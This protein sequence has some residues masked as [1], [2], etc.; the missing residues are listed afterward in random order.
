MTK[1]MANSIKTVEIR[2]ET[3]KKKL[4]KLQLLKE[5]KKLILSSR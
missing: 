3:I 5:Q 2:I 4:A 1:Q